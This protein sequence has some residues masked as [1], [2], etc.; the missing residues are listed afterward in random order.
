MKFTKTEFKAMLKETLF[1]LINEGVFDKKFETLIESKVKNISVLTENHKQNSSKEQVLKEFKTNI[2][3]DFIN[4]PYANVFSQI[5]D[6]MPTKL[7][8]EKESELGLDSPMQRIKDQEDLNKLSGG[9]IGRWAANA[10]ASQR[11]KP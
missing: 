3:K 10:F 4:N 8:E 9:N 1:E 11:K 2:M 6:E 5:A 7:D